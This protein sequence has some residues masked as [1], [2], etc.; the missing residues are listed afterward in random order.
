[1]DVSSVVSVT[2][3]LSLVSGLHFLSTLQQVFHHAGKGVS[4]EPQ[5][6]VCRRRVVCRR[7]HGGLRSS[8]AFLADCRVAAS[9]VRSWEV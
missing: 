4:G 5:S 1:M 6:A 8:V 7:R 3:D 9:V 2:R